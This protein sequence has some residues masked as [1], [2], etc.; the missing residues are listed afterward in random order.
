MTLLRGS[1]I[2][3]DRVAEAD[4]HFLRLDAAADVGLGFV[5]RVVALLDVEGDLVGAAVLRPAQ[6]AD[7]AGDRGIDVRAGAGDHAR[8]EGRCVELVLGVQDQRGMHRAHPQLAR[9]L[10][11]CSRCRKWP[12]I[13]SSSVST[14]MRRPFVAVV[15]PVE[16]HRIRAR[17]SAGRRCRARPG[18]CGRP[19]PAA[20]S[21]APRRRYASRPSDGSTAGSH[22]SAAFT[23]AG[24]P[25]SAFSFALYAA[26]SAAFGS[27][28]WT[29]RCAI[30]SNSHASAMS[31]MS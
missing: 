19:S 31:R 28:P 25:R 22:S 17:P 1:E 5:G 30:S 8:R 20:R 13:E 18:H 21:R 14:S 27:L 2:G 3:V 15:V 26:S 6:R 9:R 23:L 24:R 11:P 4:D 16:Q 7:R 10:R 12:P 29:S